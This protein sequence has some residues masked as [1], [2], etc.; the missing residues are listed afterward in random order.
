MNTP[1]VHILYSFVTKIVFPTKSL[2]LH[3]GALKTHTAMLARSFWTSF[4][5]LISS[6]QSVSNFTQK[7][8]LEGENSIVSRSFT[9]IQSSM[10]HAVLASSVLLVPSNLKVSLL[11]RCCAMWHQ[12]LSLI[13]NTHSREQLS[14][15]I[16]GEICHHPPHPWY[17]KPGCQARHS[18][19]M[20]ISK[21]PT[22]QRRP[23]QQVLF[24]ERSL[25]R[26]PSHP[27]WP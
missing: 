17:S 12:P 22:Q 27:Q 24:M 11:N 15:L 16:T 9:G 18:Y 10:V 5:F 26:G 20:T 25:L 13:P 1:T 3:P 4:D 14:Y 2:R 6:L 23:Y 19:G 21:L 8:W 7:G